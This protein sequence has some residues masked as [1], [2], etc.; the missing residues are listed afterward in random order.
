QQV[1]WSNITPSQNP[2]VA[3]A[4]VAD[5][6]SD[7]LAALGDG[8]QDGLANAARD[9]STAGLDT[10][11]VVAGM[12]GAR[13][14]RVRPRDQKLASEVPSAPESEEAGEKDRE[15]FA[16]EREGNDLV[17]ILRRLIEEDTGG[18]DFAEIASDGLYANPAS[19]EAA[20]EAL[21]DD[22]NNVS[23]DTTSDSP[24]DADSDPDV[25][26]DV[27][28]SKH[29]DGQAFLDVAADVLG[30]AA[31]VEL[32]GDVEVEA[33][34]DLHVRFGVD[35]DGFFVLPSGNGDPAVRLSRF[36]ISGDVSGGGRFGF[37]GVDLEQATLTVDPG[38]HVD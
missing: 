7:G 8:L 15:E 35:A 31:R 38:A 29:L 4:P 3:L 10:Q 11:S 13:L 24:T 32:L 23:L 22:P 28:I 37:L 30:G 20:L 16:S 1:T 5:T 33:L 27:R 6:V 18:F 19:I 14:S 36:E 21:D 34:V 26:F 2:K 12:G 9:K 17:P 25:L